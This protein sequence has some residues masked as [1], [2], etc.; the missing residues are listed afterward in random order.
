MKLI[1]GLIDLLFPPRRVCPLC[2]SPENHSN[3][4]ALCLGRISEY[5]REPVC[6]R[7][8]RYFRFS[9]EGRDLQ[10]DPREVLCRD[11]F[12][13]GRFFRMARSAGPYEG[14]LKNAVQRLKFT[15]RRGL[16]GH[17][18]GLM[19]Q[20]LADN[21]Y[22]ITAKII[23]AVPLSRERYRQRG[24]NQSE[25]LAFE[26][27]GRM[28][29]PFLPVVRKVRDTPPQTGLS[30]AGREENLAGAF[31]LADPKAVRGKTVMLVDDVITTGNTLNNVSETL[32]S[33]G[34]A[35]VICIAA[36]AGRTLP[37]TQGRP[38]L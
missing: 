8:G 24:F 11:C 32:I 16:A 31:R 33:G 23:T 20:S 4:C 9:P 5:R 26:L 17:L 27:A 15:G 35:T 2:G 7:C 28:S 10:A 13:R 6:F 30:R 3:I 18:A 19:F 38:I 37:H 25:L 14:D 21:Q 36:A 12:Q 29:I 1:A 34:A 22:Y